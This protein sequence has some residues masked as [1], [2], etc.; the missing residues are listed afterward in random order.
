MADGF[1]L[2]IDADLAP[3][4]QRRA[5]AAG[6][7]PEDLARRLLAQEMFDYDG[8]EWIGDD[9]RDPHEAADH[10]E[11]S[12]FRPWPEVRAEL[13]ARLEARLRERS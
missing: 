8:Y 9:P 4:L 5:R 6:V 7:S 11:E 3:D 10:G 12:S 13:E 1:T 2:T